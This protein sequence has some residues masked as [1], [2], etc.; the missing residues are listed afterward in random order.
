MK[1]AILAVFLSICLTVA[2]LSSQQNSNSHTALVSKAVEWESLLA[3][4]RDVLKAVFPQEGV[5]EHYPIHIVETADVI[6]AGDTQAVVYLGNGG[7]SNDYLTLMR[8]QS[9]KPALVR[10]QNCEGKVGPSTFL[11]GASVRHAETLRL[12][13]SKHAVYEMQTETDDDGEPVECG[14]VAYVWN[15]QKDAFV[16]NKQLSQELAKEDCPKKSDPAN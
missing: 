5:E 3:P 12:L 15:A 8:I 7:A 11:Q 6:G 16:C 1:P 14:L 2:S 13:P 10:F 9:G 4:I